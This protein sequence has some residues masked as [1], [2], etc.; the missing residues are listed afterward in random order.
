MRSGWVKQATDF[1]IVLWNPENDNQG[2]DF[3]R[4]LRNGHSCLEKG[5][6]CLK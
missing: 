5:D 3:R 6:P 4:H 1:V 2:F